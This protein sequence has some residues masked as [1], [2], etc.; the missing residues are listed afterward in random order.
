MK[1][2]ALEPSM[3]EAIQQLKFIFE[4]LDKDYAHQILHAD[5]LHGQKV[6]SIS[7]VCHILFSFKQFKL[8]HQVFAFG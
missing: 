1:I 6:F 2:G 4:H 5:V 8:S 7:S 3:S